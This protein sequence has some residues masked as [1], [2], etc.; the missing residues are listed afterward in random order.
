MKTLTKITLAVCSL[1]FSTLA[2]AG[3][4]AKAPAPPAKAEPAKAAPAKMEAPKPSAEI[5][6]MGKMM[7][8]SWKCTGKMMTDPTKPDQMMDMKM[9]M[10]MA[11]DL[12]NFWIKGTMDGAMFKGEVTFAYDSGQKMYVNIVRDSMGAYEMKWS[13]GMKDNKIVWDGDAYMPM[14]NGMG[15]KMKVRETNDMTDMKAGLKL[16]GEYSKDGKAYLKVWE[17]TC[18][19]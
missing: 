15:G 13:S 9:T 17:A 12:N 18:K 6:E 14:M 4:A 2:L 10:K 3:D 7:V 19:K 5:T 1:G 11:M 16:T 8:G